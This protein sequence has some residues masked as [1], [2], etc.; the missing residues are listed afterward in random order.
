[1]PQSR[2]PGALEPLRCLPQS[3]R[4]RKTIV[5][6]ELRGTTAPNARP[7]S[8][9]RPAERSPPCAHATQIYHEWRQLGAAIEAALSLGRAR[10][11]T[12]RART[13]SGTA[14]THPRGTARGQPSASVAI[15]L[16]GCPLYLLGHEH[17]GAEARYRRAVG[18]SEDQDVRVEVRVVS[19]P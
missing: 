3:A 6:N 18:S 5:A 19:G 10:R 1:M 13:P 11:P 8:A 4:P 15:V 16:P 14:T 17:P 2:L 12:Y 9:G 7:P